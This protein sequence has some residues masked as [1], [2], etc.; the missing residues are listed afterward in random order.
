MATYVIGATLTTTIKKFLTFFTCIQK[1]THHF[2]K[3]KKKK[4]KIEV[5]GIIVYIMWA[6][7]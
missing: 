4:Q 6:I 3:L 7:F 5:G 2:V 1:L